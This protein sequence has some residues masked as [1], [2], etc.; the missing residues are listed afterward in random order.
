MKPFYS[1][2]GLVRW[3]CIN[4]I[5]VQVMCTKFKATLPSTLSQINHALARERLYD[6][7]RVLARTTIRAVPSV[8]ADCETD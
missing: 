4:E 2:L 1:S 8:I 3:R 5:L 6:E 7:V